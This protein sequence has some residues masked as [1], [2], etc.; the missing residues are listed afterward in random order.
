MTP[1]TE[2][3]STLANQIASGERSAAEV[4]ESQIAWLETV[5]PKV[6]ALALPRLEAAREEAARADARQRAGEPLGPLHGVPMTIKEQFDVAGMPTNLGVPTQSGY[7]ADRDG[8]LV[9]RLR[10]AGAI[11]MG[12][13]NIMMTLASWECD[14][15]IH[16]RTDNPWDL[17]RTPG[18]SSGGEAA[19]IAAHGSPLGL[20]GDFGGSIRVPA[21]W[22]G[23]HGL[24]PTSWRLTN[25]DMPGH[26]FSS[27]QTIVIAQP[28]PIA[29]SVA[30]LR[31]AM[32]VMADPPILEPVDATPPVPWP[33][34]PV[35]VEG[36]RV[37]LITDN[38]VATPSTAIRRAAQEAADILADAGAE[39][40][41]F[42]IPE[43]DEAWRLFLR[44]NVS[45]W[46]EGIPR[47]LKGSKPHPLIA[48]MVQGLSMPGA[49]RPL[50]QA[51]MRFAGQPDLAELIGE[52]RYH[53]AEDYW[54]LGERCQQLRTGLVARMAAEGIDVLISP[55]HAV[56][57]PFH[58]LTEQLLPVAASYGLLFNL[59]GL[60]AGVV[61]ATRVRADEARGSRPKA[62]ESA[63]AAN[64]VDEGSA[65]LPVGVQ[66]VG[67][68]WRE[69]VV[70][71]A[72]EA[73][74]AGFASRPDYPLTGLP[75][76]VDPT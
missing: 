75:T 31:L 55:P 9:A 5:D 46:M 10:D 8:P 45:G 32:A 62:G 52:V 33:T 13:T 1:P 6:N 51:G 14:N 58:G 24:K 73:L 66:V 16:G 63:A 4:L 15:P 21:H 60:P 36:L 42:A 30:D 72:M 40:V 61:A 69:D 56:P 71:A 34:E 74:E 39:L 53:S 25:S 49:L 59:T 17:S 35:A 57:A 2:D 26:L 23:V 67:R 3:A 44:V 54:R 64:K 27:G 76:A 48:G 47:V 12:K 18:G 20:G 19:L 41:D 28:G 22:C 43:F 68:P 7:V 38:G 37:A 50:F 70:L 65:G 29:R 11:V